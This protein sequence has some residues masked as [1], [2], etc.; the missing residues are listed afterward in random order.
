MGQTNSAGTTSTFSPYN[1][2]TPSSGNDQSA[3]VNNTGDAV[4]STG[5]NTATGNNSEN[6]I[7]AT[8]GVGPID[9]NVGLGGTHQQLHRHANITT[10]PANAVGNVASTSVNQAVA[11]DGGG[12][13]FGS[14]G[15]AA[16]SAATA[17]AR[18]LRPRWARSA[19]GS[20]RP[21][22]STPA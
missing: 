21:S 5:G 3:T 1:P 14:G 15:S 19:P 7:S 10:G 13:G 8:Q 20:S 18:W 22:R 9:A 6:T 4:A 12:F 16:A 17:V 11:S 2:F